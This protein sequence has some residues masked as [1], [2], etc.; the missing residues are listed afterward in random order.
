MAQCWQGRGVGEAPH[1]RRWRHDERCRNDRRREKPISGEPGAAHIS[2]S[3]V[4][5]QPHAARCRVDRWPD[6]REHADAGLAK[7]EARFVTEE[8]MGRALS[9]FHAAG[10][11]EFLNTDAFEWLARAEPRSVHAVVTDPP[12]GLR[13][14]TPP[15]LE[16]M[17]KGRGGVWRL[18][19]S[20][21]GCQR[22]PLPRFTVLTN[23]DRVELRAFFSRFA[24]LLLPVLVP[25]AHVFIATN[26]L[27]SYLV[28][29]PFIAAGFEKR[30]EL[31]RVVHTLRGGDRPKNAHQEFADITVMPKSCFEPWGIFR[32]PCEGRVQDNLRKWRTGGLRRLSADEPFKDLV[33]SSPARG[34]ERELAPHPSLKPQSFLRPLVRASLPF[35]EG[36]LLD[37]FA[38]SGSTIAAAAACSLS[39]VGLEHDPTYYR[40]GLK[41]IPE[42]ASLSVNNH[43]PKA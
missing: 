3:C 29:E 17:K 25:G 27:V 22:R 42:L 4:G 23:R 9:L 34:R 35:G 28:Y 20:F 37:A 1:K 40:L 32:K 39:S 14:Y 7:A 16:K 19:P 26:P 15:E 33:H 38:G 2:T 5:R 10:D 11:Y 6:R 13:E 43:G 36:V 31:I 18:P 12:Y 30:G 8:L 41:A 21:D 24:S